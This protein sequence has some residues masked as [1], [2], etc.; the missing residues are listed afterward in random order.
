VIR[1]GEYRHQ[2]SIQFHNTDRD[3]V[4]QFVDNWYELGLVRAA[5]ERAPGREV[6]ASAQRGGRVPVIFR[7]RY[8]DNVEPSMRVV[9]DSRT[10]KILSV[11]D[12]TGLKEELILT[13]EE[14]T[15]EQP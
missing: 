11:H 12:A 5:L 3:E 8:I 1:A 9:F 7:I 15:E 10:H 14:L 13:T 2:I 4:G 6:W